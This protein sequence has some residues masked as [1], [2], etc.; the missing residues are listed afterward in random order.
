MC[1]SG[2]GCPFEAEAVTTSGDFTVANGT[3]ISVV[4][5]RE[6]SFGGDVT[7]DGVGPLAI[8]TVSGDFD[9]TLVMSAFPVVVEDAGADA[10]AGA[11]AGGG[12]G[13]LVGASTTA[14]DN[15]AEERDS[16]DAE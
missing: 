8:A 11:A 3:A 2:V 15:D 9:A 6:L 14:W 10:A 1:A 5:R 13:K 16:L 12:G 7:V 4:P